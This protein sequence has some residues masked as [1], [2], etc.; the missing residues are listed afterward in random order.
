MQSGDEAK[1]WCYGKFGWNMN[2]LTSRPD[3]RARFPVR[4]PSYLLK[5]RASFTLGLGW[6]TLQV[7]AGSW[8]GGPGSFWIVTLQLC[9]L[10]VPTWLSWR[11][12]GLLWWL[13]RV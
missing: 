13:A 1:E 3:T 12:W 9:S 8:G 11:V 2:E 7:E 4:L 6:Y 5:P 10:D